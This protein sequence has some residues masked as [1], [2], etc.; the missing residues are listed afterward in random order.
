MSDFEARNHLRSEKNAPPS[1]QRTPNVAR[2]CSGAPPVPHPGSP[3]L[4]S[5][6][7]KTYVFLK[8]T[9]EFPLSESARN[10]RPGGNCLEPQCALSPRPPIP[11]KDRT[12]PLPHPPVAPT[13][14]PALRG[15]RI[16]EGCAHCRRTQ[17]NERE[18]SIASGVNTFSNPTSTR[19]S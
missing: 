5:G 2:S 8:E 15:R 1:A 14:R 19:F 16:R 6:T 3:G 7:S 11:S 17:K 10:R 18:A 9:I 12:C 4:P 13:R